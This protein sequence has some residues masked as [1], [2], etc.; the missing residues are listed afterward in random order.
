MKN[1]IFLLIIF[2]FTILS[3]CEEDIIPVPPVVIDPVVS[4]TAYALPPSIVAGETT[5][6]TYTGSKD[7]I[8]VTINGTT[9]SATSGSKAYTLTSTTTF[10]VK[11]VGPNNKIDEK[12]FTVNVTEPPVVVPTKLD[13]MTNLLCLGPFIPFKV[14]KE[15]DSGVWDEQTM[16]EIEARIIWTF[17]KD[18]KF[19]HV[20]PLGIGLSFRG[21]WNFS[22]DLLSLTYGGR[23][24]SIITL[25]K[26][27]IVL[28]FWYK[29]YNP[30]TKEYDINDHRGRITY[31]RKK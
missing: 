19:S 18:G 14:E 3:G 20:D 31:A 21:D 17:Y 15:L 8:S 13:T 9:V 1:Q 29:K 26:D 11:F 25:D 2:L 12:S 5:T 23:T 7:V 6:I 16:T 24:D 4:G 28:G 27:K 30:I 10:T 22:S